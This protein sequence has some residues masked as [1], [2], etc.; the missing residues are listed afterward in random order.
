MKF[1]TEV[2]ARRCSKRTEQGYVRSAYISLRRQ[3]IPSGWEVALLGRSVDLV[4][5]QEDLVFTVEFKKRDWKRALIQAKDHLLGADRAYICVAEQEPSGKLMTEAR[6]AG[7][8]VFRLRDN[9]AWPFETVV[10]AEPSPDTWSVARD[11]L[12][13][14][15]GGQ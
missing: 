11:R 7:I 14:Q 2:H 12:R 5:L 6:R 4:F 3:G 13:A 10:P 1:C 9:D 15:L 8:G